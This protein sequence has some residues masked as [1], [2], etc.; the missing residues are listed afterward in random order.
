M[1]KLNLTRRKMLSAVGVTGAA[2]GGVG[3][4]TEPSVTYAETTQIEVESG[5]FEVEWRETYNGEVKEDTR[6]GNYTESG[7]VIHLPNV[8]PGDVGTLS[9]RLTNIS[10][11]EAE[12]R[13]SLNLASAAE[14]GLED[15]EKEAGDT[16]RDG[17][18]PN[19]DFPGE[20]QNH[21]DVSLW[22]DTGPLGIDWFGADNATQ[23]FG[24]PNIA[25]GTLKEVAKSEKTEESDKTVDDVSLGTLAD[26]ESTSVAFRWEFADA[27]DVNI[28]QGDSV[29]FGFELN[30]GGN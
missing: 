11:S 3:I 23:E 10:G 13:L 5:T 26:G 27:A 28:T 24:E 4:I 6:E 18:H 12:P 25:D 7:R 19:E 1:D 15:P 2:V 17:N 9:F 29:T 20:L 30:T 14:N 21:I 8:L 22:E 16:S